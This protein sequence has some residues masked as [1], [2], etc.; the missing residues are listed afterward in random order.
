VTSPWPSAASLD[1]CRGTR[2]AD[3][4]RANEDKVMG[5]TNSLLGG[6]WLGGGDIEATT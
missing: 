2:L 5:M 3:V 6:I 1:L 4:D